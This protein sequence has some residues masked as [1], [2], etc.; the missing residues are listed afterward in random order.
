MFD[1]VGKDSERAAGLLSLIANNG[2]NPSTFQVTQILL[3]RMKDLYASGRKNNSIK[4]KEENRREETND[5]IA[6][7]KKENAK[8]SAM[9]EQL[10]GEREQEKKREVEQ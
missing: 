7:L 4:P 3:E 10:V 5:L 2:Y 8:L 1:D 6:Q 9:M